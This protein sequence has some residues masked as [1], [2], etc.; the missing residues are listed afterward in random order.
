MGTVVIQGTSTGIGK[1]F[2][3]VLYIRVGG[4]MNGLT[5]YLGRRERDDIIPVAV[6]TAVD[7]RE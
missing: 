2:L 6:A 4:S 7:S 1:D 3:R 5:E